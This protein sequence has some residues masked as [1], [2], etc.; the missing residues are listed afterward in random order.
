VIAI[1]AILAA[2]LFPVFAQAREK[3][4]QAACLSNLK[5]IGTALMMYTQDYDETYPAANM[6][7]VAPINGGGSPVMPIDAQVG[8]Y[9]KNDQVWTCPSDTNPNFG[10]FTMANFWDG[11]YFANRITRTYGY[12]IEINTQE[13]NARDPNTGLATRIPPDG[14]SLASVDQSANTIA[15]AENSAYEVNNANTG[16]G[17]LGA[18]NGG[19]FTGCDTWK[20]AGRKPGTEGTNTG[21]CGSL[22]N[23]AKYIPYK[24]HFEKGNY[25]FAD[26]HVKALGWRQV[27][28]NDF[29]LFK[30]IKPTV[31]FTP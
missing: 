12:V 14:Y 28:E 15:F 26:G 2:I 19:L 23:N 11:K 27:R 1:I 24:G 18:F 10:G 3:A 22:F 9:I 7:P 20:L 5:Q 6:Q 8:P 21:N 16:V 30:R 13:K 17:M 4:R 29:W 31:T 25:I